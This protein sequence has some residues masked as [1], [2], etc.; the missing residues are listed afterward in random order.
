MPPHLVTQ[1]GSYT[2][3]WRMFTTTFT[4]MNSAMVSGRAARTATVM[5]DGDGEDTTM[6]QFAMTTGA[7]VLAASAVV[8]CGPDPMLGTYSYTQTATYMQTVPQT[9]TYAGTDTGTFTVTEGSTSDYV[10]NATGTGGGT[11]VLNAMQGSNLGMTI[12]A[13]QTCMFRANNTTTNVTITGGS[14]TLVD[15]TLTVT[16][17]YNYT[18]TLLGVNFAGTGS[19]T[20]IGTRR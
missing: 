10:F 15:N 2:A 7:L 6:K 17:N 1:R 16:G 14:G 11:C 19:T 20:I 5:L 3:S 18:G 9:G 8:G 13:N 12:V 4:G